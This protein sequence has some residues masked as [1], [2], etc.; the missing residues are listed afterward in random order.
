MKASVPPPPGASMPAV[1]DVHAGYVDWLLATEFARKNSLQQ[2]GV[3]IV[4][5][6]TAIATLIFGF[7]TG[8]LGPSA[9]HV[10][11]VTR[12]LA[13]GDVALLMLAAL[14]ATIANRAGG[15]SD[16]A[17][18]ALT[19]IYPD[20]GQATCSP[21]VANLP[22]GLNVD[23]AKTWVIERKLA[24]FNHTRNH[25]HDRALLINA[26]LTLEGLAIATTIALVA[27]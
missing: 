10:R 8:T 7:L 17:E 21:A 13:I 19:F 14:C 11:A 12:N 27:S 16:E 5:S 26:A 25:N 9:G 15:R 23:S 6:A 18:D 22:V 3:A 4:T 2:R 24:R 20:P 1:S